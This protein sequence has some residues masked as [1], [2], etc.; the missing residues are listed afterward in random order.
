MIRFPGQSLFDIMLLQQPVVLEWHGLWVFGG[1]RPR[2]LSR[3]C[4]PR[5]DQPV[6]VKC[7]SRAILWS[8]WFL[9]AWR[10]A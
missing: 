3:R 5:E 7:A 4:S 10:T 2:L 9:I 6:C 1:H 8:T